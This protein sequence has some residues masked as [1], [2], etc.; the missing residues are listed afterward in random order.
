MP[1]EASRLLDGARAFGFDKCLYVVEV[2]D[3]ET[4][5]PLEAIGSGLTAEY[6]S[7]YFKRMP[8][9][10]LRRMVARGEIPVGNTPIAY[11]NTGSAL[12][13]ALD[14]RLSSSDTSLLRWCLSQGIRTGIGFRIRMSQGR[15]ASLNFYSSASHGQGNLDA[16]MQALFLIG[17]QIHARL[18]PQVPQGCGDLLSRREVECLDWIARGLG[19]RQIA[20]TLGLSPETVK[21][22]VSSLFQKLCVNSRAQAVSRGHVLSYLG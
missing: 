13:I 20:D 12:S 15:H 10:P 21:D 18:E 3:G 7:G 14:R 19:N 6:M 8:Q 2:L 11:E 4:D 1:Y 16:A 5:H 22:H 9:D 17:H